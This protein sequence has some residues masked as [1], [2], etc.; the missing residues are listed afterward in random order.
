MSTT[1]DVSVVFFAHLCAIVGPVLTCW[2][3][4]NGDRIS[5]SRF[6]IVGWFGYLF[7]VVQTGGAIG[8]LLEYYNAP[9][10]TEEFMLLFPVVIILFLLV[11][12]FTK[13]HRSP[14][15]HFKTYRR[16]NPY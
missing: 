3:W 14:R 4:S 10:V 16:H 11:F 1:P 12:Y 5:R 6:W 9:E 15:K 7:W 13:I 8:F 2:M